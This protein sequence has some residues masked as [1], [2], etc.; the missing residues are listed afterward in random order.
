MPIIIA[1]VP[2][3]TSPAWEQERV[4][5]AQSGPGLILT[6]SL[7]RYLRGEISGRSVLVAGHR[8]AGKSTLVDLALRTVETTGSRPL[9]VSLYGPS[10]FPSDRQDAAPSD[11]KGAGEQG[12]RPRKHGAQSPDPGGSK[13][14]DAQPSDA[15]RLFMELT[16]ALYRSLAK[17]V[18]ASFERTLA[19]LDPATLPPRH[20][21]IPSQLVLEL[22]EAPGPDRLRRFWEVLHRSGHG[23]LFPDVAGRR[24]D[25]GARELVALASAAQAFRVVAGKIDHSE[26]SSRKAEQTWSTTAETKVDVKAILAA[27]LTLASGLFGASAALFIGQAAAKQTGAPSLGWLGAALAAML[28]AFAARRTANATTSRK[29]T[30]A[31]SYKFIRDYKV[32]TLARELPNLIERVRQA[33]LAPVFVVDELDKVPDL[34]RNLHGLVQELK[35]LVAERTFFCFVSDR[36]YYEY[37]RVQGREAPYAPEHTYFT[38]RL[39]VSYR[40]E[41]LRDFLTRAV[42]IEVSPGE[43]RE[44]LELERRA[45]TYVMLFRARFHP[46]ELSRQIQDFAAGLGER[47]LLDRGTIRTDAGSLYAIAYQLAVEAIL[48]QEELASRIAQDAYFGQLVY[49]ALYFPAEAWQRG[50]DRLDLDRESLRGHLAGRMNRDS[51]DFRDLRRVDES[52]AQGP[53]AASLEP[54]PHTIDQLLSGSDLGFLFARVEELVG[55]LADPSNLQAQLNWLGTDAEVA[56]LVPADPLLVRDKAEI[57]FSYDAFGRPL[58]GLNKTQSDKL[59]WM[60]PRLRELDSRLREV[61]VRF[62]VAIGLASLADEYRILET[63]PAWQTVGTTL[64][65]FARSGF[66]DIGDESAKEA[67][68]VIHY[69]ERLQARSHALILAFACARRLMHLSGGD[70][71][72]SLSALSRLGRLAGRDTDGVKSFLQAASRALEAEVPTFAG[73]FLEGLPDWLLED[74]GTPERPTDLVDLEV[75]RASLWTMVLSRF[76]AATPPETPLWQPGRAELLCLAAKASPVCLLQ[77]DLAEM[78]IAEWTTVLRLAQEGKPVRH[79]LHVPSWMGIVALEFLGLRRAG[80]TVGRPVSEHALAGSEESDEAAICHDLTR[81]FDA[82]AQGK[83]P[84]HLALVIAQSHSE[85]IRWRVGERIA[86]LV[87]TAEDV[88]GTVEACVK[89]VRRANAPKLKAKRTI[90]SEIPGMAVQARRIRAFG[91]APIRRLSWGTDETSESS[92]EPVVFGTPRIDDLQLLLVDE[93]ASQ[94]SEEETAP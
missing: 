93:P 4:G 59:S 78:S 66:E 38:H 46:F 61:T 94:V 62:G 71:A 39:Y 3:P 32:D 91:G 51:L 89:L 68:A 41:G 23:V 36:D 20:W 82:R 28:A 34:A 14:R 50:D 5:L 35:P 45:L 9:R 33:G 65:R 16:V 67:L 81:L 69:G 75:A 63:S 72:S 18:V 12:K 90:L 76:Q 60:G 64:D 27:L 70:L 48:Q 21:E 85:A 73:T 6:R 25:Q 84:K 92:D 17:E 30:Q 44:T 26:E 2:D 57:R 1:R 74:A 40:P 24:A 37:L 77:S 22:D 55:Y 19:T 29:D 10:L 49:D 54:V 8:G 56:R 11:P 31:R 83:A 47:G 15:Q 58:E 86:A 52:A 88:P 80:L 79:P 13:G 42:V 53:D 7:A 87:M 43:H